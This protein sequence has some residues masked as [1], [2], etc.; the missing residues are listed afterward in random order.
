MVVIVPALL[1]VAL[2][3]P[4]VQNH[5]ARVAED[6]LSQL[7][8]AEV[9]IGDIDLSPFNRAILHD[10]VIT[11]NNGCDTI[12]TADRISGAIN[13]MELIRR[14]RVVVDYAEAIGL[15][16]S[17]SR[18]TPDGPL[19]ISP[20][21]EALTKKPGG[22][23]SIQLAINTILVRDSRLS[24]N[25]K[26]EPLPEPDRFSPYHV[27]IYDWNADFVVPSV[28]KQKQYVKAKR[29]NFKETSGLEVTNLT[30]TYIK[31]PNFLSIE[32]LSFEMPRSRLSF[33]D[34]TFEFDDSTSLSWSLMNTPLSLTLSPDSHV[35]PAD[36][37][38]ILPICSNL[39][40]PAQIELSLEGVLSEESTLVLDVIDASE[41]YS[42]AFYTNIITPF[43]TLTRRIDGLML[44]ASATT[45]FLNLTVGDRMSLPAVVDSTRYITLNMDADVSTTALTAGGEIATDLGIINFDAS[46]HDFLK[47]S[48]RGEM[49]ISSPHFDIGKALARND[50]SSIAFD[51]SGKGGFSR[52]RPYG[53]LS[54]QLD[55]IVTSAGI[56]TRVE[57]QAKYDVNGNYSVAL[58]GENLPTRFSA[59]A[60]GTIS[61]KSTTLNLSVD[62]DKIPTSLSHSS[63]EKKASTIS[64]NLISNLHGTAIDDIQGKVNIHDIVIVDTLNRRFNINDIA[65]TATGDM[66]DPQRQ[67]TLHSDIIDASISGQYFFSSL[68]A[69]LKDI[70]LQSF[71]ALNQHPTQAHSRSKRGISP[72][73]NF[74]YFIDIK[75]TDEW[76]EQMKRKELPVGILGNMT[77][78]GDVDYPARSMRMNLDLPYLRQGGKLID[79]TRVGISVDGNTGRS[80]L[81]AT[82]GIPTLDGSL[83][84]N[85]RA[86]A[87]HNNIDTR[88]W[89][90]IGR[91][92][93][94]DG[95]ISLNTAIKV[96]DRQP[97]AHIELLP[98]TM[99]FND[100][101]WMISPA[102]ID[103]SPARIDFNNLQARRA[104]QFVKINGVASPDS[105]DVVTIDVLDICLDDIFEAL[106]LTKV[107][108]GGHATGTIYASGL[109]SPQPRIETPGVYV[110][111]VSY[112]RVVLGDGLVKSHWD[113]DKG[114]VAINADIDPLDGGVHSYIDGALY[115]LTD[116]L[117]I[118]ITANNVDVAFM[119]PYMS[120]FTSHVSGRGTGKLHLMGSFKDVDME[121]DVYADSLTLKI[122][123]TNTYYTTSDWIHMSPGQ[124]S[125]DN[126]IIHDYRGKTGRLTGWVKHEFFRNPSFNFSL[127][128]VKDMLVYDESPSP[129]ALWYGKVFGDGTANIS[130]H[131][132]TVDIDVTL[133]TCP[134]ST[135]TYVNNDMEVAGDYNFITFRDR[136]LLKMGG[137]AQLVKAEPRSVRNLRERMA[138]KTD[139]GSDD[140][141]IKLNVEITPRASINMIMDSSDSIK[142]NGS[143]SISIEYQSRNDQLNMIGKY[144]V[145]KGTY[146][147]TLQELILKD[148]NIKPGSRITFNGD[149]YSA[150]LDITTSCRI[151]RANLT[152]LDE[153]FAGD[154]EINDT[155]VDVDAIVTVSGPLQ[156]IDIN[157][158]ID[159][160]TLNNDDIKRKIN[161]IIS[162]DEMISTQ[163]IY[164]LALNTFYTPDYMGK[165]TQGNELMS[166]ASAT[167]SSQLRNMLGHLAENWV[168]APS[169]R[170]DKGNFSEMEV[171]VGLSSSLLNN[172]LL[173]NGNFG[174]RDN[175]LNS[176][177]FVGD[178]DV[179]YLLN[180]A[181][182][183]RLKGYNRFNDQTYYLRSAETTQ[184][185]GIVFRRSFNDF[186]SF[187]GLK[188]R[189][190]D[191][192][193]ETAAPHGPIV[194]VANTAEDST[195]QNIH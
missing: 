7:L 189:R 138:G 16:A 192:E 149:P 81:Y 191:D 38:P 29:L 43:D 117:D 39:T 57:G 174:Y 190:N 45:E 24:Y 17:L 144:I 166:V 178:F 165:T 185:V 100:S 69:Q 135:F 55:S 108:L 160:P 122:D 113:T 33:S 134:G 172:R 71:P 34:L 170:S 195:T 153:S 171:N 179:E 8:G 59:D 64:F 163:I 1:F 188:K 140:Y 58:V 99:T 121:G 51:I 78:S 77:I 112:N 154:R 3:L 66:A 28:G 147:F 181:G 157:Y 193:E 150:L 13:L 194:P 88:L 42:L 68:P 151:N 19:N 4:S 104:S 14:R 18:E 54:L 92:A 119:K 21:I 61:N 110:N 89:W 161:S 84:F 11:V 120:A 65:I 40:D 41:R 169:I 103:V 30:G 186:R 50:L 91:R 44:S 97:Q 87:S 26:S 101:T 76:F 118:R 139:E 167:L 136:D 111:D 27:N 183:W 158:A 168:I 75:D 114:A 187:L 142:S 22:E 115:P 10:V 96:S 125:I 52:K 72:D 152:D 162:T 116:S 106:S 155:H 73:N 49:S 180:P 15:N 94:Y 80:L 141:N 177:Q 143:G 79:S 12:V 127:T 156:D 109:L 164:L 98:G 159:F 35:T 130:G 124:I 182:T 148:F 184:G 145:E 70:A 20:I 37:A 137:N 85:I 5:I 36:I 129:Q 53:E 23:S 105:T 25:V 90:K 74:S 102:S 82:S 83:K 128:D 46:I 56:F 60:T 95:D 62:A 107:L 175:A 32:N 123:F 47:D 146:N 6:E 173:F 126:A 133:T 63:L 9:T 131:P 132:G 176:N 93:R 48:S 2:S 67:L 31:S 86:E